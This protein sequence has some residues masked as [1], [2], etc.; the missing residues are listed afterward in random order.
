MSTGIPA[1]DIIVGI[2]AALTA[3][4]VIWRKGLRPII[5][6]AHRTEEALPVILD[7]ARE[8]RGNNGSTL[9]DVI[10]HIAQEGA[11]LNAY[12]H[13]FKHDFVN[14]LMVIDGRLELVEE[15]V[16]VFISDLAEVRK[17]VD[18]REEPR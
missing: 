15:K 7:I 12:A 17:I 8:F 18:R 11:E 14:K 16:D 3:L 13:G 10:D 9:R 1:V 4:G 6:A 5:N 2:A